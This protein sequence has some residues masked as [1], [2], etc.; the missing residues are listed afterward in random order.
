MFK[1]L[2]ASLRDPAKVAMERADIK[3]AAHYWRLRVASARVG[4]A[5]DP[6]L[7]TTV[8]SPFTKEELDRFETGMANQLAK[9]L[10]YVGVE[11][12]W[13]FQERGMDISFYVSSVAGE[14][15]LRH[16][17]A[18]SGFF[19]RMRILL[20]KEVAYEREPFRSQDWVPIWSA[21][22]DDEAKAA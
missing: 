6:S 22:T 16:K 15:N 18:Y 14:T 7:E 17:L 2:L 19:T 10:V 9:A 8:R 11:K 13:L 1:K 12:S 20:D 3:A 4:D 21:K 5:Q